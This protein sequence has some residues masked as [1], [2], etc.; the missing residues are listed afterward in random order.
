MAKDT[1]VGFI[2]G[3]DILDHQFGSINPT[4]LVLV[5]M[6]KQLLLKHLQLGNGLGTSVR[7]FIKSCETPND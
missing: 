7:V 2:G 5:P 6:A 3:F 1:I 4:L